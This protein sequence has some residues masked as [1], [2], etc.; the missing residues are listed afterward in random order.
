MRRFEEEVMLTLEIKICQMK[1]EKEKK[2]HVK[3][4][5][6]KRKK[7]LNR[8]NPI[9][10]Y[11]DFRTFLAASKFHLIYHEYS[12]SIIKRYFPNSFNICYSQH[13]W[14]SQ[15]HN[16]NFFRVEEVSWIYCTSMNI[17]VKM[18]EKKSCKEEFWSFFS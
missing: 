8:L 6:C 9:R 13:Y 14:L 10:H 4:C 7:L 5:Y 16:Q 18:Q 12:L 11:S 1:T 2:E 3:Y 17:S 15:A